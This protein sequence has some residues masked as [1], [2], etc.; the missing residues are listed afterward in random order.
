MYP[1]TSYGIILYRKLTPPS[2]PQLLYIWPKYSVNYLSFLKG[3]YINSDEKV[4]VNMLQSMVSRMSMDEQKLLSH[5]TNFEELCK[6]AHLYSSY[7]NTNFIKAQKH[8][9]KLVRGITFP[10]TYQNQNLSECRKVNH[11]G[12]LTPIKILNLSTL[13]LRNKS[14]YRDIE[15]GFPKGRKNSGG[16]SDIECALREFEEET[17]ISRDS[18]TLEKDEDSGEFIRFEENYRGSDN[19]LYKSIFYVARENNPI[20]NQ[21][22]RPIRNDEVEMTQWMNMEEALVHIRPYHMEKKKIIE[23]LNRKL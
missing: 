8:Y 16:E 3:D 18:I 10:F 12:T 19:K 7:R 20:S 13:I 21:I 9:Y 17:Q 1:I 15:L 11:D 22:I 2:H 14:D 23:T 4:N 6:K 5:T